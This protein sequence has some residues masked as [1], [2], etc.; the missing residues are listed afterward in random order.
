MTRTQRIVVKCSPEEMRIIQTHAA[1]IGQHPATYLREL[2]VAA[3]APDDGIQRA[4]YEFAGILQD[5]LINTLCDLAGDGL[6][7]EMRMPL[8]RAQTA[9][10]QLQAEALLETL[11]LEHLQANFVHAMQRV[12]TGD[13]HQTHQKPLSE[14]PL[15]VRIGPG[16]TKNR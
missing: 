8:E 7:H 11:P 12:R 3:A 14:R 2:G 16:K 6:A 9:L 15:R 4:L 1:T 10:R 5:A 13:A